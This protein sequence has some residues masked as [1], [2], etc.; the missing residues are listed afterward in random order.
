MICLVNNIS[1]WTLMKNLSVFTLSNLV[2]LTANDKRTTSLSIL[3]EANLAK[4][5]RKSISHL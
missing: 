1:S 5:V 2:M 3:S 4:N